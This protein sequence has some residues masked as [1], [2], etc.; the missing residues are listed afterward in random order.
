[1][2]NARINYEELIHIVELLKQ[3]EH[4]AEFRLKVGEMEVEV[5]REPRVPAAAALTPAIATAPAS[6]AAPQPAIVPAAAA[7][8]SSNAA[9]A[10]ASPPAA[11]TAEAGYPERALRI[12][13]PM[14]GT[15]YSA[16]EP[17]AA[18]FVARGKR[19]EAGATLCII[20]VM[21]LM[22]TLTADVAGKVVDVLVEDGQP[23]EYG[24]LLMVI[25]PN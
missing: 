7:A 11:A 2:S 17:G 21:K 12:T 10:V 6:V 20:E 14:V 4:F 23:V 8:P 18:P 24:Q 19:V 15:F 13:A 9:P 3:A 22:N 25:E 5:R 1:V 16:P